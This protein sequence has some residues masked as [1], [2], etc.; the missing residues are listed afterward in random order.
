MAARASSSTWAR[1]CDAAASWRA[2]MSSA[3]RRATSLLVV[4]VGVGVGV[5]M[6]VVRW[7]RG[8][9]EAGDKVPDG[10]IKGVGEETWAEAP[11]FM[12]MI[13]KRTLLRREA[14]RDS[15]GDRGEQRGGSEVGSVSAWLSAWLSIE[16]GNKEIKE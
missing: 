14:T 12:F 15:A 16:A 2:M 6:D 13:E 1:C 9:A 10:L 7:G 3:R 5:G 11:M 4:G 8:W